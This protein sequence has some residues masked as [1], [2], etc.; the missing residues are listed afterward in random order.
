MSVD[1]SS[2]QMGN[3]NKIGD[4][5][6]I[7]NKIQNNVSLDDFKGMLR[8]FLDELKNLDKT[9]FCDDDVEDMKDRISEI[10]K[11]LQSQSPDTSWIKA[12]IRRIGRCLGSYAVGVAS[13]LTANLMTRIDQ[14]NS[15]EI[16]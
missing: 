4:N 15:L 8:E 6:N 12:L 11:Q 3:N 2:F 13:S 7:G 1:N 5:N 10:E 9:V 16:Q 14:I